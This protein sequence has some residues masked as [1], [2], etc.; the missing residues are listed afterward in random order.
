MIAA[1]AEA[2]LRSFALGGVVWIGLNLF[3]VRNPHVHMTAWI[4]VLLASLAMP[5]V[6]HWPTLTIDR[7]PLSVPV[8]VESWPADISMLERPQPSLPI[9]PG[10]AIASTAKAGISID[11]WMVATGVYVG[12]AGLLLLR[13]AIGLCLTWRLARAA[14]PVKGM[15]DADVRVSRDV[16]GPVTFGSTILVPP[17]FFGW[18]AK[19]RLA[20][21]AHEGAHVA[22]RDF[23][24][25][26][27]ASLNRVVFWFSPFSWWQLARLAELAEIISDARAIEMIDDRLSYAEILLDVAASVKP[28]PMELAMAQ[29]ATVRARIERIIAAAA[30][31]VAVGW[32][33]R[34]WIAAAIVPVVIASAGMIA[35]RT[36]DPVASGADLG[37][38]PAEHYRPFVNFYAMGPASVFAIFREGDEVYGQLTGQRRLRISVASDGTASYAAS[39]GEITFPVDA[40]RRS[41]ELMLHMNGRNVRAV[42]VAE[43][44]TP[45]ADPVSLDQYV[46]WYRV[47]PN[48]VLT[49][50]RDGDGLQVQETGQ[51]R[52]LALA[53]GLDAFSVHG[54]RLLIFLRDDAAKVSRVL[55]HNAVSG[56]RLAQRIDAAQ[57]Q[58]IEADFARRLAEVPDRFRE[59]VPA[60]G[61]KEIILTGIEDLRRGTPNYGRMS[62]PLAAAIHGR[63]DELRA[64]FAALGPIESIFFRG[65]GPG[66]Y[67]IYGAKFENGTAEFRV[68][69]E[70][71][72]KAGDVTFRPDGNDELGGIFSCAEEARVRGRAGTSPIR[73]MLYNETEDDIQVF[74]LGADGE[75]KAQSVVRSDMTWVALT[76]VNSPWV[77]A[78]KSGKCM[79]ILV[80][81]RQTR[82]HNVEASNLVARPGRAARRAVPIVN[83]EAMLR[84]Y[85]EGIAKGQPDYDHMTTEVANITRAQLPFDQAILARLG[86]LRAVSFR[87]VTALDSDIYV[88]QF[89]NG[90]AE[91]RI[92]VRNGTI[93]KIALGPNF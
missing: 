80:P 39:F 48:R 71:D 28:R 91:W 22:N 74:N 58:A 12:I 78:D 42:R 14:K 30:M 67:D 92:G 17:Q 46:G 31:P 57:A 27:L 13:L 11:W 49:V 8:P 37:D 41:S 59:Q 75:R 52:S 32:R 44:P 40:E 64:T 23:Y 34:L 81:G 88:A 7:L 53:E 15:I 16:G 90:A 9:A 43:M 26:L 6:M 62:A 33:K 77:I 66:G 1:L 85:L 29:A 89:A 56:A 87:G 51:G 24:V 84:L 83:G 76:N 63:L 38:V 93:T 50:R 4:V 20:V 47:A 25:L 79:E 69:L 3:R 35:Y 21:L 18:D 36:P 10:A 54:D 55:V 45:A 60:A 73:I 86:A 65:V 82:F 2:A 5:V 68:L 19:K 70:P 61:S 72:G